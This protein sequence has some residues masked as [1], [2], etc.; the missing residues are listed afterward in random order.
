MSDGSIKYR[1]DSYDVLEMKNLIQNMSVEKG[2]Y[3][4]AIVEEGTSFEVYKNVKSQ[5]WDLTDA[6]NWRDVVRTA[7]TTLGIDRAVSEYGTTYV[8]GAELPVLREAPRRKPDTF[9]SDDE[10]IDDSISDFD[11]DFNFQE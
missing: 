7:D 8:E 1:G 6:E 3:L 2:V 4:E 9:I 11:E 10:L 5:L